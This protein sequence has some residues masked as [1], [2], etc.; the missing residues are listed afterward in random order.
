MA[1][2]SEA[3]L[4]VRGVQAQ[5]DWSREPRPRT[6]G[7]GEDGL[8]HQQRAEQTGVE[9]HP[10]DPGSQ[11][12][13]N[14]NSIQAEGEQNTSLEQEGQEHMLSAP[15]V[16]KD[17]SCYFSTHLLGLSHRPSSVVKLSPAMAQSRHFCLRRPSGM[18]FQ[19]GDP[20]HPT[21]RMAGNRIQTD[22]S[23]SG[24]QSMQ[25]RA[26]PSGTTSVEIH[27]SYDHSL[28]LE[29]TTTTTRWRY[30]VGPRRLC[31]HGCGIA[32]RAAQPPQVNGGS[33]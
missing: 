28:H 25:R 33:Q 13:R 21:R 11:H 16:F 32:Q 5:G 23:G 10:E 18:G 2:S 17:K 20:G 7:S 27:R 29:R 15:T 4:P 9:R 19:L 26:I 12:L 8:R 1:T 22:G 31:D 24:D 3:V 6:I 30:P 14:S